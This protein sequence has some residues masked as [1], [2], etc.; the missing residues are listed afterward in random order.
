MTQA[1]LACLAIAP[2]SSDRVFPPI[3]ISLL[4]VIEFLRCGARPLITSRS[5]L[6][7]WAERWDPAG[8]KSKA[9]RTQRGGPQARPLG[10]R[11]LLTDTEL[12]DDRAVPLH[13]GLL[14]VVKKPAAASD[15]L[16]QTATGMMVLR[17]GL[18]MLGEVGDRKSTRLN[19]S[20]LVISYAVFCLQN[21]RA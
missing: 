21:N 8:R 4:N 16:Q 15:E 2:V 12:V 19:S 11:A 3:S 5:L 9:G 1:P 20:H 7:A 17:M 10:D 18:E 6:V 14:E 13:I